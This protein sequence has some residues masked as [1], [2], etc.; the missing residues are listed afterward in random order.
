MYEFF[1]ASFISLCVITVLCQCGWAHCLGPHP[2][3][4]VGFWTP[5]PRNW[6]MSIQSLTE[7]CMGWTW[8]QQSPWSSHWG[9]LALGCT[10]ALLWWG[11][12]VASGLW[13]STSSGFAICLSARGVD[14]VWKRRSGS[15]G[16][17]GDWVFVQGFERLCF[18]SPSLPGCQEPA[19]VLGVGSSLQCPPGWAHTMVIS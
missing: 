4:H 18:F 13:T 14:T 11:Q 10:D 5:R 7:H 19:L 1:F 8:S 15:P 12:P 6:S 3:N 9:M 16:N 17:Q 2:R